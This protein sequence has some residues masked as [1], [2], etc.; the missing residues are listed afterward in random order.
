MYACVRACVLF[1]AVLSVSNI[2][3]HRAPHN[4]FLSEDEGVLLGALTF[5]GFVVYL[6][7]LRCDR[8][9]TDGQ[10]ERRART[11]VFYACL[12]SNSNK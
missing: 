4:T 8:F 11:L 5:S 10:V 12:I 6:L 2:H 1:V 9:G 7:V 3:M